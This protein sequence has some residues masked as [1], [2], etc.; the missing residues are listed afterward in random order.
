LLVPIVFHKNLTKEKGKTRNERKSYQK[1]AKNKKQKEI[2]QKSA[3][4]SQILGSKIPF[5][6]LEDNFQ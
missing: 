1:K 4:S 2:G 6:A 3:Q 5:P